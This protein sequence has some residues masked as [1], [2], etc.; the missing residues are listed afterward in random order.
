MEKRPAVTRV[1]SLAESGIQT[2]PPQYVWPGLDLSN[3][4]RNHSQVPVIDFQGLSIQHLKEKTT[5]EISNAAEKW[6]FFQ[7][8]N[9]GIPESLITR[10]Q[11]VG[12]A[13]FDLPLEEKELYKNEIGGNPYGYGSKVGVSADVI[14]DWKDYYYNV[15]WPAAQRDMTKWPKRPQDF[16]EVMDEYG[17]EICRLWEVL[18]QALSRGLR[19]EN[20]NRVEEA[21]GGERK[22]VHLSI[23]YYPPCP[24][25]EMVLGVAPHSDADALTILL[26]N[27]VPGLQIKKDETW[28]DVECIPGALVVN[29]GDQLEIVS[30][31]KY[32]SIEHRSWVHKERARMSW[33]MFCTPPPRDMII[34]PLKELIDEHN[35]PLY[36]ALCFQDYVKKFFTKGLVG[37]EL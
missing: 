18:M 21:M 1:Q 9:H 35:P 14:I 37:K 34:S 12:K 32:K 13:F 27:Q 8:V 3:K 16:T 33:A 36:E 7:I 31:G 17:R 19:L 29:V 26:H 10:V 4:L 15:V 20:E 11:Q 28:V 22:E 30:N 25:P 23:N 2:V 24:Q 6:G 5:Q